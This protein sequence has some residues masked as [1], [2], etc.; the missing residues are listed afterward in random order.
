MFR[1]ELRKFGRLYQLTAAISRPDSAAD[2]E[3]ASWTIETRGD[4]WQTRTDYDFLRWEDLIQRDLEWPVWRTVSLAMAIYWRLVFSGTIARFWRAHWR[5]A[6]FISYPHFLLFVEAVVSLWVA[7]AFWAGL[8]ALG[9]SGRAPI[10]AAAGVFVA[11]L[12]AIL[13]YT[14]NLTYLLSLLSDTIF[15]WQFAHR[16]RPEWDAR[17]DRFARHLV[18]VASTTAAEEI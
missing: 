11:P 15:P 8:G 2:G 9:L 1:T 3:T 5:F 4:D 16:G 6:T 10:A 18:N 13:K 12:V 14:E 17:I 7:V